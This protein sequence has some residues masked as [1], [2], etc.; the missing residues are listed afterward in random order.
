[1]PLCNIIHSFASI[2]LL[3]NLL[4]SSLSMIDTDFS[5]LSFGFYLDVYFFFDYLNKISF[6]L[7]L[8][9]KCFLKFFITFQK[10]FNLSV[11]IL[12]YS[13]L[14]LFLRLFLKT[15][16]IVCLVLTCQGQSPKLD[17]SPPTI[18]PWPRKG[19]T[20]QSKQTK[21]K[22]L[23]KPSRAH[24]HAKIK[25]Y[26]ANYSYQTYEARSK[27]VTFLYVYA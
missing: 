16:K 11:L 25:Q 5:W 18:R 1:M 4:I 23:Y 14:K 17:F 3:F 24:S 13:F 9:F 12:F 10:D 22:A 2:I 19:R 20:P 6:D 27:C 21:N 7:N 8:K 26:F 15:I